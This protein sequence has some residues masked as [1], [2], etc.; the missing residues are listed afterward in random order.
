MIE[1]TGHLNSFLL[2]LTPLQR[3]DAVRKYHSDPASHRL[4]VVVGLTIIAVL[5]IL[6]V[7]SIYRRKKTVQHASDGLF[8][9]YAD[10]KALTDREY[11]ILMNIAT[12]AGLRRNEFIFT[13]PS[14]FDRQAALMVEEVLAKKGTEES[15]K[16]QTEL[17]CLREKLDFRHYTSPD[18]VTVNDAE[19]ESSR[20]IPLKKKIY[21]KR[22]HRSSNGDLEAMVI[23]NSPEGLTVQF[24]TPVEIVFGQPWICRYYTGGFIAEFNT[25]VVKCSGQ[26]VLLNHNDHIRRVNRRRFL[27]VPTRQPAYVASF[28]FTKEA[29]DNR[30]SLRKKVDAVRSE[31][32]DQTNGGF[33]PPRFVAATVTELGGP[34]LRIRTTLK[35]NI[36]DRVLLMFKLDQN[37]LSPEARAGDEKIIEHIA[38][39]RHIIN[40]ENGSSVALE[41]VGLSDD[42]VNELICATNDA[43]IKLNKWRNSYRNSQVGNRQAMQFVSV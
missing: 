3:L 29:G 20:R 21:I 28:P 6:L 23:N 30:A 25:T 11:R 5:A 42:G 40:D 38:K 32:A 43:S 18:A 4:F 12:S 13:L 17:D 8:D 16:L 34:G 1:M 33:E 9:E 14:A 31:S 36:G 41:L 7:I 26:M 10:A 24:N 35:L 27:R 39:V 37:K 22:N 2:G 19:T 15:Q